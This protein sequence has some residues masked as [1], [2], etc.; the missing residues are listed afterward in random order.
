MMC[1]NQHSCCAPCMVE[2]FKNGKA[3][4]CPQCNQPLNKKTAT[5]NRLLVTI[6]SLVESF[7]KQILR[8]QDEL[9]SLK[10]TSLS[11]DTR[12]SLSSKNPKLVKSF[13]FSQQCNQNNR[14]L[15][16]SIFDE[17]PTYRSLTW[18][19][20][21][22]RRENLMAYAERE[23]IEELKKIVRN[24]VAFEG[25]TKLRSGYGTIKKIECMEYFTNLREL[26]LCIDP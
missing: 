26:L 10:K 23:R 4:N 16:E 24:E 17:A 14:V 11:I 2:L 18:I 9:E 13:I 7:K 22:K 3:I 19:G 21:E 12:P 15:N 1:M 6:Y 20:P 5:K 8:L 25:V